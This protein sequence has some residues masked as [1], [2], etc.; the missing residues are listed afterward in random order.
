MPTFCRHNRFIERC[1]ICSKTLPGYEE[2]GRRRSG[3][4]S[5]GARASGTRTSSGGAVKRVPGR[6]QATDVRVYVDGRERGVDDGYSCDLVPGLRSSGDARRLL[7]EIGFA[8]AR[9]LTL[10]SSPPSAYATAASLHRNGDVESASWLC[11][12]IAYLSPLTG[13]EPFAGIAAAPS[14]GQAEDL[15]DEAIEA[16]A[17][18][19]RTCHQAGRGAATLRAY[20]AWAR[21]AGSQQHALAGEP[22]WSPQR[23]FE[24]IFERLALPGLPRWG[25]FELLVLL[26][27]LGP[28]EMSADSLHLA[29]AGVAPRSA[30]GAQMGRS[31]SGDQA[32]AAAKRIFGISDALLL[33][34]RAK[35]LA[36]ELSA[37]L[38]AIEL[39][40][41]NWFAPQRATLGF[42]GDLRDEQAMSRGADALGL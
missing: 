22:S 42:A 7:L 10:S 27:R 21:R 33:E 30:D 6:R 18:G 25:R 15:R 4:R 20:L 16:L 39:A 36:E 2:T 23:R 5:G 31:G 17:L 26:G 28:Y 34:R 40:L 12:L 29:A 37:P 24:R 19:P 14:L 38:E 35:R 11:F 8:S 41:F 3:A 1:P 9:L 13:E 32:L